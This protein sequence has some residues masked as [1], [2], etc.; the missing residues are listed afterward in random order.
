MHTT[1]AAPR[2]LSDHILAGAMSRG[3]FT[4][5]PG[6]TLPELASAMV[7]REVHAV[8]VPGDGG[9]RAVTAEALVRALSD[10]DTDALAA[11]LAEPLPVLAPTDSVEQ[12]VELMGEQGVTHV[13]VAEP[14][15][16]A[17]AG[18]FSTFNL[19]ATIA[20][21][22][23]QIARLPVPAPAR[24]LLGATRLRGLRAAD[25]MHHGVVACPPD[26]ALAHVAAMLVDH[27]IHC[28]VVGGL[29]PGGGA[30][31][32]VWGVL[33]DG[34][35]VAGARS[36]RLAARA[37]ELAATEPLTVERDEPLEVAVAHMVE[38]DLTHLIVLGAG[39]VPAGIVS[40]IDVVHILAAR[41]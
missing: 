18:M 19:A 17:P 33:A 7:A 1:I 22:D 11:D 38:H 32:L 24:P 29:E 10:G 16:P 15:A 9:V 23:P 14:G 39:G 4:A 13:V 20:G 21:R 3:V 2:P 26:A 35:L 12:A 31:R 5:P 37:S 8:A 6:A 36:G 28:V 30:E 34:D 40:T 41:T 27:R 25:V